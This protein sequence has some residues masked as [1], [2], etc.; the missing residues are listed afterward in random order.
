MIRTLCS[1]CQGPRSSLNRGNKIPQAI[2]MTEKRREKK[3]LQK[4]KIKLL[5]GNT[6]TNLHGLGFAMVSKKVVQMTKK[7][8][9]DAL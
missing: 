1:H 5:E 7:H 3:V 2:H 6:G 9:K 8:T 4:N